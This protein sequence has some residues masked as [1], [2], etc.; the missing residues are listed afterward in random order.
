MAGIRAI[1]HS[2]TDD[3]LCSYFIPWTHLQRAS[4]LEK[5]P[6]GRWPHRIAVMAARLIL[7]LLLISEF[8]KGN[9][10]IDHIF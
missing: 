3:G 10:G 4:V 9:S 2:P 8:M 7:S 1:D 6:Q 5:E